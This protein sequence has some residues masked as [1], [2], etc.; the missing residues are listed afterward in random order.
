MY[1]VESSKCSKK[2][3]VQ[4]YLVFYFDE[5]EKERVVDLPKNLRTTES[6]TVFFFF[7]S[8]FLLRGRS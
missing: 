3:F 7:L 5:A 8:F 2:S 4:F 6:Q 1:V